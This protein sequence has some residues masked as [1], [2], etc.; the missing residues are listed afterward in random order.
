MERLE[1]P[2]LQI[3]PEGVRRV[4]GLQSEGESVAEV[5]ET[6]EKMLTAMKAKRNEN[7]LRERHRTTRLQ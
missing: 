2:P 3:E 6:G 4:V 7:R 1:L 5:L